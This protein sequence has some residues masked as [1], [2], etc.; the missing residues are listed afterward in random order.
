MRAVLR[1]NV[2]DQLHH[3]VP[4]SAEDRTFPLKVA[5]RRRSHQY[6]RGMMLAKIEVNSQSFDRDAVRDIIRDEEQIH[7]LPLL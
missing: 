7:R 6:L 2:D 5:N 4:H 3:V 1:N